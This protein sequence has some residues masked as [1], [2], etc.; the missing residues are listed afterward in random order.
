MLLGV[1][2]NYDII[3]QCKGGGLSSQA[4]AIM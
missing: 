1:E 2:Y 4:E 3:I